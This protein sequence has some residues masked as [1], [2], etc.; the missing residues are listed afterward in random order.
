MGKLLLWLYILTRL[1]YD[2]TFSGQTIRGVAMRTGQ[3]DTCSSVRGF[4]RSNLNFKALHRA[5]QIQLH[6]HFV[7]Y[8]HADTRC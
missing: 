8:I 1:Q 7:R 5:G 3:P 4:P 2:G 6:F